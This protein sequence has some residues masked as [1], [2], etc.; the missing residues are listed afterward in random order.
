MEGRYRCRFCNALVDE[1][2]LMSYPNPLNSSNIDDVLDD[3]WRQLISSTGYNHH[4]LVN[5]NEPPLQWEY[6][7]V[8]IASVTGFTEDEVTIGE[9]QPPEAPQQSF[10]IDG[11]FIYGE[12]DS[13]FTE[14]EVE[15][16]SDTC[17][18]CGIKFLWQDDGHDSRCA[19]CETGVVCRRCVP[20]HKCFVDE[21]PTL[22]E[23]KRR[24][25]F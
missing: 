7:I 16:Y 20:I 4:R 24:I 19:N 23:R 1:P 8:P 22:A 25:E 11:T 2:Q 12:H 9:Y 18:D 6:E 5:P 21:K 15:Q 10:T 3:I 13:G 17:A 14:D